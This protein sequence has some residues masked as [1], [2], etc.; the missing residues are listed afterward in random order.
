MKSFFGN[1]KYNRFRRGLAFV[2][3]ICTLLSLSGCGDKEQ[4][5][6]GNT[7]LVFAGNPISVGEVYIYAQ[8]VKEDY[9]ATY[10]KDV[11]NM[12]ITLADGTQSNMEDATRKDVIDTIVRVKVLAS[13][14]RSYNIELNETELSAEQN[15]AD[16]FFNRLTDVQLEKMQISESLVENVFCENALAERVYDKIVKNAGIELSDEEARI[17]T[18]YDMFFSFYDED[19][20]G[21]VVTLTED[22]KKEQ[23][24]KALQAYETLVSPVS[25]D[26]GDIE[27]LAT[28]YNLNHS[29]YYSMTKEEIIKQY[30]SE[31]CDELYQLD[32]GS[33]SLVTETKYGYHIFYMKYLTDPEATA[34]RKALL[35]AKEEER[36]FASKLPAWIKSVDPKYTYVKSVNFDVYNEISFK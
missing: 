34:E 12:E 26:S 16:I 24:D 22:K 9:E 6:T 21:N 27:G 36:Y 31:I 33:Y 10:G 4:E 18:F 3:L 25:E 7:V 20:K 28:Y 23:Y 11:W 14:S 5:K 15:K 30:G 13:M 2:L 8:I 19:D 29:S 32:D 35:T 17:T 1:K